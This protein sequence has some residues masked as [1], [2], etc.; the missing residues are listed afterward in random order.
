MFFSTLACAAGYKYNNDKYIV[1]QY[2]YI[3]RSRIIYLQ[4]VILLDFLQTLQSFLYIYIGLRASL[5][6]LRIS[7]SIC[8][9]TRATGLY[10]FTFENVNTVSGRLNIVSS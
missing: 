9:L 3:I 10:Y 7:Y 6:V 4:N 2:I 5:A 1:M 8:S